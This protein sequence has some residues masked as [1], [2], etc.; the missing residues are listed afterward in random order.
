[1]PA[2]VAR[3]RDGQT[4]TAASRR[5]RASVLRYDSVVRTSLHATNV[6]ALRPSH[7]ITVQ[8]GAL[9]VEQRLAREI[10]EQDNAQLSLLSGGMPVDR[11]Y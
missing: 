9:L 1:V 3:A 7:A 11:S 2:T 8:A 5:Q 10:K 4:T 6:R